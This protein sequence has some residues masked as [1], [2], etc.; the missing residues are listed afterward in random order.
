MCLLNLP[1]YVF[2]SSP[3]SSPVPASF[4]RTVVNVNCLPTLS[5]HKQTV[6]HSLAIAC[7]FLPFH[8][9][10]FAMFPY[11]VEAKTGIPAEASHSNLCPGNLKAHSDFAHDCLVSPWITL[12]PAL[13]TATA[14]MYL[15]LSNMPHS[16]NPTTILN[17]LINFYPDE[18]HILI[19]RGKTV[20]TWG[21][22]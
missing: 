19:S 1:T 10:P 20:F 18:L 13:S 16:V 5:P 7:C 22:A 12:S 3:V 11:T 9:C 2:I 21:D 6:V 8:P 4:H 14:S 15:V 17:Q